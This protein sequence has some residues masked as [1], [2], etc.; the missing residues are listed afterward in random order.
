MESVRF[1]LAESGTTIPVLYPTNFGGLS[2]RDTFKATSL[3]PQEL[4]F[5]SFGRKVLKMNGT[6]F[7]QT[8]SLAA[9]SAAFGTVG[10]IVN[11]PFTLL[12][13]GKIT[14][15]ALNQIIFGLAGTFGN[16]NYFGMVGKSVT[17][18]HYIARKLTSVADKNALFPLDTETHIV[19]FILK[20]GGLLDLIVDEALIASD[21]NCSTTNVTAYAQMLVI[22]G[23]YNSTE[24]AVGEFEVGY[25]YDTDLTHP[26]AISES[27]KVKVRLNLP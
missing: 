10:A 21:I 22:G 24:Y 13:A 7:Y 18:N 12:W 5:N 14:G 2:T 19:I 6:G 3:V 9:L 20:A 16:S 4:N 25:I 26:D 11:Q 8:G 27:Q 17:N 1:S 23:R 15:T